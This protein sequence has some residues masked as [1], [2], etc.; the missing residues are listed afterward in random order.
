MVV[1]DEMAKTEAVWFPAQSKTFRSWVRPDSR[2]NRHPGCY[3]QLLN[4]LSSL[5]H[6]GSVLS[7]PGCLAFILP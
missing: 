4:A 3:S 2:S 7:L 1:L 5:P 6:K